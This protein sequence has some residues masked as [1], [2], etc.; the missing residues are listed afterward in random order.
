[1]EYR[2]LLCDDLELH[3]NILEKY[4][5]NCLR[6]KGILFRCFKTTSGYEAIEM[7]MKQKYDIVFLDIDMPDSDGIQ[8][9]ERIFNID[10][11]AVVIY[12]TAYPE[13]AERAYEQFVF[14]YIIKPIDEHR[15]E[16][17][18]NKAFE[19]IERDAIYD[20]ETSFFM[21]KKQNKD[22]KIMNK[23]VLYFEKV[24]N[25]INIYTEN[26]NDIS[27]RMTFKELENTIDMGLFL[28]CHKGF[29]VNKSKIKSISAKEIEVFNVDKKIPVGRGYKK[30]VF[31]Y[32]SE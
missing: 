5:N 22:I 1:M 25:Y 8:V 32:L 9:A 19:K 26:K 16:I 11:N 21:I 18:L 20:N 15:L 27:I 12:V 10:D 28:R 4:I 7:Y 23:D 24:I 29:I 2:F 3:L 17:V 13:Y 31:D 6:G 14:Q 30:F